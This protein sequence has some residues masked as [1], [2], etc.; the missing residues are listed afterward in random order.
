MHNKPLLTTTMFSCFSYMKPLFCLNSGFISLLRREFFACA[1][2]TRH[3]GEY[4]YGK[5]C[6]R[7][8][9][10]FISCILMKNVLR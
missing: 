4:S 7:Y 6:R 3:L 1:E 5:Y 2:K 8:A 9:G 10:A